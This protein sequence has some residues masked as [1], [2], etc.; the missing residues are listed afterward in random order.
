MRGS[1]RQGIQ[2]FVYLDDILIVGFTLQV[3]WVVRT[4]LQM[5]MQAG[6]VINLKSDLT[7]VQDLVYIGGWFWMDLARIFLPDAR[8]D[9]LISCVLL[10]CQAGSYKPAH[11]FLR[12]L[13]LM[14]VTL[15]VVPYAHL[16]MRPIQWYFKGRWSSPRGLN[17]R[18]FVNAD[19]VWDLQ[20]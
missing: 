17:H 1:L 18:V 6:Y 16:R 14:S 13:G 20:L 2:I 4:A 3:E 9:A 11:Q 5:L 7:P 19:L 10:L 15:L 8:K 12:L